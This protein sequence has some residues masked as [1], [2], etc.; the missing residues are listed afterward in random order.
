MKREL[1]S[2]EQ[3]LI[4]DEEMRLELLQNPAT[5]IAIEAWM[6]AEAFREFTRYCPDVHHLGPGPKNIVFAPGVMGSTLQSN[7]LGGVWWLDMVRARDKLNQL[8]LNEDGSGDRDHDADVQPGAVDLSYGPFRKAIAVSRDFGGSV[9]FPYDWRKSLR[10]STD[11]LRDTIVRTHS[12]YQKRVHLVGHSMGGLM[13][14]TALMV[15]GK[16]LWPKVDRVVFIGTPHYGSTSIAGYLKNHLWGFEQL[17]ILSMF[18]SRGTFRTLRGVLSLLP[19]PTGIYPGT[20]N[21]EPHPCANFDLYDAK[22]WKLDLDAADTVHLQSVLDEVRQFYADL[23]EWHDSLKQEYKDQMLVIA[24]VGQETLF[25]LEFDQSFWGLW[26]KTKKITERT[27]CDPNREGDG[28]V[29]LASAELE[30]VPIRYVEGVH[31]GLPNIPAVAQEVLAWLTADKLGLAQTC[32]GALGGHLSAEDNTSAA[33]LLD[34]SGGGSRYREL[35]D[36]EHPTPEF[37]AKIAADLDAGRMPQMNLVK[38][39]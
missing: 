35:L 14:R 27:P 18:L 33:P 8:C 6:G 1:T 16:E 21:G 31:G 17:A 24:G 28:R 7:G 29:P 34:G 13:I 30:D 2:L 4:A 12:E 25:R 39:L 38:I 36:Y 26:E 23:Y 10:A 32:R 15:H 5:K 37:R 9:H 22:A 20:R 11:L 19:A 3:F